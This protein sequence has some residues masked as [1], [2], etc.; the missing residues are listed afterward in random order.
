MVSQTGAYDWMLSQW[1]PQIMFYHKRVLDVGL[2][3]LLNS[4][5][6]VEYTISITRLY[7]PDW[8]GVWSL[9]QYE[10]CSLE[11]INSSWAFDV[12]TERGR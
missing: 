8:D 7:M 12:S 6:G 3:I 4:L 5:L 10:L 9:I 1:F 2:G 11:F